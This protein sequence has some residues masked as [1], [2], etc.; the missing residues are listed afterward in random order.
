MEKLVNNDIQF[1]DPTSYFFKYHKNNIKIFDDHF[2]AV[3]HSAFAEAFISWFNK[4]K[5]INSLNQ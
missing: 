4:W 1:I 2:S 5:K 3:G